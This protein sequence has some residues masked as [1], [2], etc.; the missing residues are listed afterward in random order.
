MLK[1]DG[2]ALVHVRDWGSEHTPSS[3]VSYDVCI[4]IGHMIFRW[5]INC[6][7]ETKSS[8]GSDICSHIV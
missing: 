3:G 8:T 7:Y 5:T 2:L 6:H 4:Y 1:A